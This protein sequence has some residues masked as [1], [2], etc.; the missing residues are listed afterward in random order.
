MDHMPSIYRNRVVEPFPKVF[1]NKRRAV[2]PIGSSLHD[3]MPP[4]P[5]SR[6]GHDP[7]GGS[8]A[9]SEPSTVYRLANAQMLFAN[10]RN[11]CALESSNLKSVI[12]LGRD[13][14]EE[15]E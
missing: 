12:L 1:A 11:Q 2:E 4:L 15:E 3:G 13:S 5:S 14:H 7:R 9:A 10:V 6:V 8:S